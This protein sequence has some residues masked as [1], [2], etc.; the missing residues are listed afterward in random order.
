MKPKLTIAI[1][2]YNRENYISIALDSI[3]IQY[4]ERIEVLVSDNCSTDNTEA[5]VKS[6]YPK[7][8][9]EKNSINL[10]PDGNFLEC[11]RKARGEYVLLLGDDD[12]LTKGALENILTFLDMNSEVFLVFLNH[13]S[14]YGQYKGLEYCK[15]PFVNKGIRSFISNDKNEFLKVA[16]YQLSFMSSCVVR[17]DKISEINNPKRYIGT[18][19]IHTCIAFEATKSQESLLGY[20]EYPCVAQNL[21]ENYGNLN[22]KWVFEVFGNKEK[23]AL[24][25]IGSSC[26]YSTK[27]LN[28]F[29][30]EFV[31][32]TWPK[33]IMSYKAKGIE[34]WRVNFWAYGYPAIKKYWKAWITIMPAVF[35]PKC[36]A[37]LLRT[38]KKKVF[39]QI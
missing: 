26:N 3:F 28:K 2:T 22:T 30:S 25:D 17:T 7:V 33:M 9:Y 31:C 24:C 11:Y 8:R 27:L 19:F 29:Y 12:V 16:R 37:R 21:T 10:G 39:M 38:V 34:D 35:C 32:T 15:E 20:I 18:S 1:P 5:L 4:D 23:Y 36:F 13:T 14:F 6:K